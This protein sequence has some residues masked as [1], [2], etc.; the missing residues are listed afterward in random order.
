MSFLR[1]CV[2]PAA[3]F[4]GLVSVLMK[5]TRVILKYSSFYILLKKQEC[6]FAI[7]N[8][9]RITIKTKLNES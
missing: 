1:C 8:H 2:A 5:C 4:S 9:R 3:L 6:N 7:G